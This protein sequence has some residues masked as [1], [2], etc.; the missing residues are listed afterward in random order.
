MTYSAQS[1]RPAQLRLLNTYKDLYQV[2]NLVEMCFASNMDEDGR[3]YIR[4]M[5][6]VAREI[7]LLRLPMLR[8]EGFVW[9]HQGEIIGNVA[10]IPFVEGARKRYLIAN[11]AVHP[12][13]RRQGIARRMTQAAVLYARNKG[14]ES[15]WLQV[16]DDNP[17]AIELYRSLNF[18]ERAR[19]TT[20]YWEGSPGEGIRPDN[21]LKITQRISQDWR[22]QQEWLDQ[23]YPQ[24]LRWNLSL[25]IDRL[26][27]GLVNR[28]QQILRHQAISHWAVRD[29]GH[30]LG[31]ASLEPTQ[32]A[33]DNLWV[34]C[35]PDVENTALLG[36]LSYLWEK[37]GYRRPVSINYP[38]GRGEES[39]LR[40]GCT[41]HNTLIWMELPLSEPLA[42]DYGVDNETDH[43]TAD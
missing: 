5:R 29:H 26:K 11:V 35:R 13:F 1:A 18:R 36:L 8:L 19:R 39:F 27:P 7:Q 37:V 41:P 15:C 4:Q 31:L 10:L 38:Y 23:I 28:L 2:A 9:E 17:G 22:C 25:D 24:S 12:H 33:T 3:M 16:R 43:S 40:A 6:R 30:L 32:M 14:A 21:G 20:W 34:A 42:R